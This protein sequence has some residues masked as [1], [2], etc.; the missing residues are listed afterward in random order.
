MDGKTGMTPK[1]QS[2]M[3][4]QTVTAL[5]ISRAHNQSIPQRK[6]ISDVVFQSADSFSNQRH[7]LPIKHCKNNQQTVKRLFDLKMDS[8][9]EVGISRAPSQSIRRRKPISVATFES[10]TCFQIKDC[11][12]NQQDVI[13]I[14][15]FRCTQLDAKIN[16][17][18]VVH[19]VLTGVVF[20]APPDD[21]NVFEHLFEL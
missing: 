20:S 14:I 19:A 4:G 9:I 12:N 10:A 7:R 15:Y 21:P 17:L 6:P 3:V 16:K 8:L 2:L 18:L 11:D 5:G 1:G 13:S